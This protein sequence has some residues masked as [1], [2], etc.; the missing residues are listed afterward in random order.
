[1]LAPL[2]FSP[3]A[4]GTCWPAN[5]AAL[6][7]YLEALGVANVP[8]NITGITYGPTDPQPEG[9]ARPWFNTTVNRLYNWNTTFGGWTSLYWPPP[10]PA[11]DS[12]VGP[13]F[14]WNGTEAQ[15]KL[16]D[17]GQNDV[18]VGA[19]QF[20]GPFWEIAGEMAARMPVGV[21]T[22]PLSGTGLVVTNTGGVDQ[23]AITA[24]ALP[25]HR[26]FVSLEPDTDTTSYLADQAAENGGFGA[27]GAS[28]LRFQ[29]VAATKVGQ[30]RETGNAPDD[31]QKLDNMPPYYTVYFIR[32]T[33][34]KFYTL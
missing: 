15:L 31:L 2:Q 13:V 32:R 29:N 5:F 9:I 22:L 1:M 28:G 10:K 18:I 23:L 12:L 33:L 25:A 17:E 20:T 30:T 16:W 3:P 8:D 11:T 21:G 24:A 34:R 19:E 4:P 6:F 14:I 7:P 27:T 26:H